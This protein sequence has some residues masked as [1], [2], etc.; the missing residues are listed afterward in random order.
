VN[1][2][3]LSWL[4]ETRN[5]AM[6]PFEKV[7]FYLEN[8][9]RHHLVSITATPP[10]FLS[11]P[12]EVHGKLI[13]RHL[14][15]FQKWH[16][17]VDTRLD[18]FDAL[19]W[20]YWLPIPTQLKQTS[21]KLHAWLTIDQDGL[22]QV[23]ADLAVRDVE[24]RFADNLPVCQIRRLNGRLTWQELPRGFEVSAKNLSFALADGFVMPATDFYFISRLLKQNSRSKLH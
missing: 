8:H 14:A 7:N 16:G 3:R 24:N 4:D 17:E 21:G 19:A 11:S 10:A 22:R 2:A 23:T 20:Q 12:I 1:N 15:D 9:G 13:G 18:N 6:L 5:S